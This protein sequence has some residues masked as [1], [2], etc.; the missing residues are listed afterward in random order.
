MDVSVLSQ[1]S[2][3]NLVVI[4]IG[5]VIVLVIINRMHITKLGP[6]EIEHKD[7]TINAGVH[8][9]LEDLDDQLRSNVWDMTSTLTRTASG[10]F[11]IQEG[12]CYLA[13]RALMYII[14]VPLQDAAISNHF[15]KRLSPTH[16]EYYRQQILDSIR[17]YYK[18]LYYAGRTSERTCDNLPPWEDMQEKYELFVQEWLV[19]VAHLT[20]E[21]C[22]LKIEIYEDALTHSSEHWNEIF[23]KCKSKNE[24]YIK[25]L[26][27]IT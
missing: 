24:K 3:A 27:Q 5:I 4:I 20:I 2:T 9:Q 8:K 23:K 12:L 21:T 18:E 22:K 26:G 7:Q 25:E 19:R 10:Q 15:T 16:R 13:K 17:D 14:S 6:L 1:I 11:D